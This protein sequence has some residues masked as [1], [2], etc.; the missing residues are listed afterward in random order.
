MNAR[1]LRLASL[2][3][4]HRGQRCVL[5][6]NGPSLNRMDLAF[7]RHETVIGLNKI[8]L[9]LRRYGFYPRYYVAVNGKVLEQSARE[10]RALNCVKFLGSAAPSLGFVEDGLTYIVDTHSAGERFSRDLCN[11]LHEG[12]TVT[13]AA[14]QVAY[15]LGFSEVVLIGLDHRYAYEGQPNESRLMTGPDTN[16]FTDSYFA[17]GQHWDNPD[18]ARS[19]ES[20][21]IA[22]QVF[23]SEGR[24]ILDA[25]V[26]GACTVFTKVNCPD[27][28][29]A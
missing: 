26:D 19:E 18:L 4:R 23:E 5:V 15:H 3:D 13:Y 8:H 22:R 6:A 10:I 28:F 1:N 11:G 27:H 9:G 14:L 12:W 7:L 17:P 2:R 29:R 16:H 25:T 20:Y 21:R 24:C